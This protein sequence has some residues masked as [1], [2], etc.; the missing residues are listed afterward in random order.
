[1]DLKKRMG[2]NLK[3]YR[4]K[5]KLSQEVFYTNMGLSPKYYACAERGEVNLTIENVEYIAS[6]LGIDANDLLAYNE[7]H[8]IQKKRIDEKEKK[9]NN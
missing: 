8:I 3:Y 5:S 4:Y 9:V 2:I 7:A 6:K 1:M